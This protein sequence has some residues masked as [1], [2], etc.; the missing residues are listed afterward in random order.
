MDFRPRRPR[1]D[2]SLIEIVNVRLAAQMSSSW[3]PGQAQRQR[4]TRRAGCSSDH[5]AIAGGASSI[6]CLIV[7]PLAYGIRVSSQKAGLANVQT[8]RMRSMK[9]ME[10][11]DGH[12]RGSHAAPYL[13]H[14]REVFGLPRG[15]LPISP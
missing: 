8:V 15:V 14:S 9:L 12:P 4:T 10:S 5:C 6:H 7:P 11:L 2:D 3:L 13:G 1:D